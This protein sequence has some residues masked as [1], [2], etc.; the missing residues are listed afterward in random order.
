MI[1]KIAQEDI[2]KVYGEF[3]NLTSG[4]GVYFVQ[5]DEALSLPFLKATQEE[6]TAVQ[7]ELAQKQEE[8]IATSLEIKTQEV[9]EALSHFSSNALGKSGIY[10][11]DLVDQ[12]NLVQIL[13]LGKGGKI[14]VKLEG[15]EKKQYVMH[16]QEEV[17]AVMKDWI[18]HKEK[19]LSEFEDYK[20]GTLQG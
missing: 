15:E 16:T 2:T 19:I 18:A 12:A 4:N 6:I 10:D 13:S 9:K 3:K 17:R 5:S 1:Y 8:G 11:S 7:E 14:Q 20:R